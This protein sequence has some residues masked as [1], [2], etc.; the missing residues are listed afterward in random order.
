MIFICTA[1]IL[2]SG[3][4]YHY[5]S[6]ARTVA[7]ERTTWTWAICLLLGACHNSLAAEK[8]QHEH[9][10]FIIL[11]FSSSRVPHHTK[12]IKH[13]HNLVIFVIFLSSQL[14]M[15]YSFKNKSHMTCHSAQHVSSNCNVHSCAALRH[16]PSEVA[17]RKKIWQFIGRVCATIP[18]VDESNIAR[19]SHNERKEDQK[20]QITNMKNRWREIISNVHAKHGRLYYGL[21]VWLSFIIWN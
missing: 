6:I 20:N 18:T 12:I 17:G 4:L 5:G 1:L 21:F 11:F 3:I 15:V 10:E 13:T 16:I 14:S 7:G 2:C 19:N 9:E 8:N